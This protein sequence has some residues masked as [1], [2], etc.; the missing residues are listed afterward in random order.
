MLNELLPYCIH[1]ILNIRYISD[2]GLKYTS[3][4]GNG[5]LDESKILTKNKII[6]SLLLSKDIIKINFQ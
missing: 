5:L 1:S 2:I 3:S 4:K 6:V